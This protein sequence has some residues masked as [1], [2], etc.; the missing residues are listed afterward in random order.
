MSLALIR[1]WFGVR[2]IFPLLSYSMHAHCARNYA[3][4][5]HFE[6]MWRE[7]EREKGLNC[8]FFYFI[9]F[10]S[11]HFLSNATL[12][13]DYTSFRIW[14]I[15]ISLARNN[16]AENRLRRAFQFVFSFFI[17]PYSTRLRHRRKPDC[18][19]SI[20]RN[21][22]RAYTDRHRVHLI[23]SFMILWRFMQW[24]YKYMLNC[25]NVVKRA[26]RANCNSCGFEVCATAEDKIYKKSLA[27]SSTC[28]PACPQC[29]RQQTTTNRKKKKA[30]L[31][32]NNC[33][34]FPATKYAVACIDAVNII[35]IING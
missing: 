13:T 28:L 12:S 3:I 17:E 30:K 25:K 26:I 35:I 4:V 5:V 18:T 7:G 22:M 23:P 10:S 32:R 29:G 33:N 2:P 15:L 6:S 24:I 21:W 27:R 20:Q 34:S 14:F 9:D 31:M 11:A 19:G 16:V 8:I 1:K